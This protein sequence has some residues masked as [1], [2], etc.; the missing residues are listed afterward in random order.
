MKRL[1]LQIVNTA[2]LMLLAGFIGSPSAVAGGSSGLA[3]VQGIQVVNGAFYVRLD[4]AVAVNP[5]GCSNFGGWYIFLGPSLDPN[6]TSHQQFLAIA[7]TAFTLSKKVNI[8]SSGCYNNYPRG[9]SINM[10]K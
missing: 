5:D 1:K 6:Q 10:S 4:P 7:V 3:D 9:A 8:F 2:F